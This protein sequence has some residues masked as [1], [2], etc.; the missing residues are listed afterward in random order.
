VRWSSV[1]V[2]LLA[3]GAPVRRASAEPPRRSLE[4]SLQA[5]YG[6]TLG[7]LGDRRS[8][9]EATNGGGSFALG[10]AFRTPYLFVPWAEI[11]WAALRSSRDA[12]KSEEFAA[13]DASS[14][15]LTASYGLVGPSFETGPLRFRAGV[16]LYR[17]QVTSTFVG[18]TIE[19]TSWDMGYFLGYGIRAYDGPRFGCGL[20][21]MGLLM[22][23]SQLAYVGLALR[24][25]GNVWADWA[26]TARR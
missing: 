3:L 22:S 12:P 15:R 19:P 2:V 9:L 10:L 25:W 8:E 24:V 7:Q 13:D 5:G 26:S 1:L 18:R 17:Q 11:G 6:D 21:T 20:E 14:S 4:L 23:E 16:G